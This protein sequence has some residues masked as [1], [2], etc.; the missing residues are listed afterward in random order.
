MLKF[1][2]LTLDDIDKIRPYFFHSINRTCDNSVGGT[3]M[4]R[5]YF[6]VEYAE[7]NDNLIFKVKIKYHNDVT[8]F[9]TPL[10]KDIKGSVNEIAEYCSF[11]KI[12]IAFCTA[13]EKDAAIYAG[14]FKSIKTINDPDWNDYLYRAEDLITLSGRRYSGQRNHINFFK[15]T[16][17]NYSFEVIC[18]ENISEV[19]SFYDS[20]VSDVES[21]SAIFREEHNKT[22]EVLDNYNK[23]RL[24][25]GLIRVD[26]EVVAFAIG[27]AIND[28]LFVHV[29]RAN[30]M[31]R[32]AYQMIMNLFP[33]HYATP[34]IK[35]INREEDVGDEGLR[36]AKN[37]LHPV[38]IIKKHTVIVDG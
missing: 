16:Y 25:G 13:T 12:P 19:K 36:N 9:A 22:L 33:A 34:E 8:A 26:K 17:E 35:F 28:T 29:E 32:G 3:F 37:A 15:K 24:P 30:I 38:E 6:S 4:W 31:Y 1:K 5:D 14:I 10:G 7:W 11:N 21:G 27:E 23:Y 18:N 20:V 2:P